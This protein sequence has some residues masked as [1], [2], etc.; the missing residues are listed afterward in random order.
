[1][2]D[3]WISLQHGLTTSAVIALAIDPNTPDIIYAG[4]SGGVFMSSDGGQNWNAILAGMFHRNVTSLS[5]DTNNSKIVY[6]GT[7]GGGVFRY[8]RP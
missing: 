2:G 1:G 6:A 7:E 3:T 5:L 8:V 4:T